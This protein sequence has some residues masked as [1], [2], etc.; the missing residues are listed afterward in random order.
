MLS[1]GHHVRWESPLQ[2]ISKCFLTR[3]GFLLDVY[4]QLS[5]LDEERVKLSMHFLLLQA[6]PKR[7]LVRKELMHSQMASL[8]ASRSNGSG[9]SFVE[10]I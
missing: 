10:A 9:S 3:R 5:G 7:K 1:S 6:L 2:L 4:E 8:P